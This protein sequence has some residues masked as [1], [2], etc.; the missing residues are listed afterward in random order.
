MNEA[1][2]FNFHKHPAI[3]VANVGIVVVVVVIKD[4]FDRIKLTNNYANI[5]CFVYLIAFSPLLL[6]KNQRDQGIKKTCFSTP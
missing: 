2:Q 1:F 3:I 4:L 5:L 6:S